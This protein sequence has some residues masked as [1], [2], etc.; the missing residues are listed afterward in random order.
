MQPVCEVEDDERPGRRER[1]FPRGVR[2]QEAANEVLRS[3]DPPALANV[4]AHALD[5]EKFAGTIVLPMHV[6]CRFRF[7]RAA[8]SGVQHVD[9]IVYKIFGNE[10]SMGKSM[11]LQGMVSMVTNTAKKKL[12]A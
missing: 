2:E 6:M 4:D 3:E 1:P 10:L 8:L 12:P 9:R 11:G 7:D 5:D